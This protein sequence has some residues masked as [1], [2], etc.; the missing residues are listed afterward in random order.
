MKYVAGVLMLL[1]LLSSCG[2]SKKK[3]LN[4][5]VSSLE[6][7][8][9]KGFTKDKASKLV[10]KYEKF[11]AEFPNDTNCKSYMVNGAEMCLLQQDGTNALKFINEF[12]GKYPDDPRAGLM[13]YK[14]ALVYDL[15]MHDGLRAVAE[16]DI[17]IR[18]YPSHPLKADAEAS[19]LLIQDPAA[20]L[21]KAQKPQ[22]ST[23]N[24]PKNQ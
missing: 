6:Q 17:F 3:Q 8:V 4:K 15:L 19:I 18:A 9:E 16:Y 5:E 13:Q 20:F 1:V 7:E 12:L 11:I 21:E 10:D 24:D 14:K 23:A 22:D 2:S